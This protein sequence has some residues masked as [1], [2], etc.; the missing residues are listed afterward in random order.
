MVKRKFIIIIAVLFL[1]NIGIVNAYFYSITHKCEND[2]CIEGH[3]AIWYV[4]IHNEGSHLVEFTAIEIIN[5]F[6]DSTIAEIKLPFKPLTSDRGDLIKVGQYKKVIVNLT[7]SIPSSNNQKELNYYPCF[8]NT[9]TDNFF[10][11]KYKKYEDRHCY[12]VNES[13]V[14]LQCV[15]NKN[16]GNDEYCTINKC[17]KLDCGQCQYFEEHQCIDYECCNTEQCGFGELCNNNT[18]QKL[19]CGVNEY[20]ENRTCKKLLCGFDEYIV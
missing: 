6:N 9:I 14:V 16:C 12:Y 13:M 17:K 4:T 7:G 5:S 2:N 19:N 20:I 11:A 10:I 15:S 3:D 18:C 8:T 1:I